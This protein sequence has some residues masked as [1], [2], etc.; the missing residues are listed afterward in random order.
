M[1]KLAIF[2]EIL[3]FR[4]IKILILTP[5]EWSQR[6]GV[7]IMIYPTHWTGPTDTIQNH[8]N[9][10]HR[11]EVTKTTFPSSNETFNMQQ[12]VHYHIRASTSTSSPVDEVN[13]LALNTNNK[14]IVGFQI[15]LL[16]YT[17][18]HIDA[19]VL[20]RAYP[21]EL[22]AKVRRLAVASLSTPGPQIPLTRNHSRWSG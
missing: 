2:Y 9:F 18:I 11:P 16:C 3:H 6:H 4:F 8:Q 20:Q 22:H 15:L 7:R 12:D 13:V 5:K 14:S 10:P 17:Y 19:R 21:A 1:E